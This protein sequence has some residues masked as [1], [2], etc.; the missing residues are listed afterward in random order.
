[1]NGWVMRAGVIVVLAMLV[2]CSDAPTDVVRVDRVE[3]GPAGQVLVVGDSAELTAVPRAANGDIVVGT[4]LWRNLNPTV[5]TLRVAGAVAVIEALAEGTVRIEAESGGRVGYVDVTVEAVPQVETVELQPTALLL[6]AGQEATIRAV[7]R[8]ADGRPIPGREATWTI[9]PAGVAT[10]EPETTPGWARVTALEAG[11]AVVRVAIEGVIG[12]AELQVVTTSPPPA[13]VATVVIAPSDFSLPVGHQTSLQATAR[14]ANGEVVSGLPV[15]WTSTADNIATV[16]PIG[17]SAFASLITIAP[18]TVRIQA[19]VGG[20]TG[21]V[22]IVVTAT[23]PPPGQANYL[24][25]SPD[26]RGIWVNQTLDFSQHLVAVGSGGTVPVPTVT[27]VVEDTT[28]ATVDGN[29][30][31]TGVRSG[32]TKVRASTGTLHA[33][34]VVTVFRPAEDVNVFDLTNDWWDGQWHMVPQV[35]TETWT[36]ELGGQH[37]VALWIAGGK[38]TMYSDGRY[39]RELVLE[40]WATWNGA[41]RKVIERTVVDHGMSSIM[42]GGETGYRMDSSTTPGYVYQILPAFNAG[43]A[44]MRARVGTAAEHDYLFR[45][46]Q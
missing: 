10:V 8:Q 4:V 43:H 24:W 31:V 27:W 35:G 3:V 21:E 18:G 6:E 1:V 9:V 42:V 26:R 34:A 37:E 20:V 15:N 13:E 32:T 40:G 25:F 36:D 38:L 46:R 39:E 44:V 28:V 12:E 41:G 14:A 16:T 30:R 7:A 2:S 17:V 33:D 45:L 5:A 23:E 29:G 22:N 11:E 19:T